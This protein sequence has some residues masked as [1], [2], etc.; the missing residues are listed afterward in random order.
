MLAFPVLALVTTASCIAAAP[1]QPR[2]LNVLAQGLKPSRYIGVATESY[3]ILNATTFGREYAK[4]ATSDEFGIYT[5]ENTLK[6]ETIEPQPGVFNF[7]SGD[8]LFSIAKQNGKKMRGH[9]LVWHSQLAPWVATNNYT[10]SELKKVMKRHVQ[11]VASHYREQIYAWD[12]VNEAF[13][14][15]G[16]FRESIW[17]NTFG[18]DYIEWAFR[19]AHEADPY[20]LKYINDYNFESITPKTN[21]AVKLVKKLKAKGVPIHGVGVQAHLIV[22]QVPSDFKQTLQRFADLGVDVALTE[23]DIR[24]EVPATAAKLAQQATDYITSVNACLGVKRCVGITIWQFTDALSWIP[25]VFPAEGDALPWDKQLKT[26]PA[27]DAM[28]KALGA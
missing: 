18:E 27:Y 22:G 21:A 16:T 15:D 3:N 5:N 19:W 8:K 11:T 10:A 28:R 26:K 7:T 1:G 17:Y 14:E 13:N 6:W 12:V 25:G 23:L 9:T 4:I 20:S 24:L 2:S